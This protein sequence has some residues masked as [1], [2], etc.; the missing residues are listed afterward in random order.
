MHNLAPSFSV[1]ERLERMWHIQKREISAADF[2]ERQKELVKAAQEHPGELV[3]IDHLITPK[4]E[5]GFSQHL[6]RLGVVLPEI[7]NP[8]KGMSTPI[9]ANYFNSDDLR[10]WAHPIRIGGAE[11]SDSFYTHDRVIGGE[12]PE[13]ITLPCFRAIYGQAAIAE[14]L[15]S[16]ANAHGHTLDWEAYLA[17]AKALGADPEAELAKERIRA[18]QRKIEIIAAMAG[19]ALFNTDQDRI[20]AVSSTMREK[21]ENLLTTDGEPDLNEITAI[22]EYGM[23]AGDE[24]HIRRLQED[25]ADLGITEIEYHKILARL[26]GL[27][28]PNRAQTN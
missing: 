28:F 5:Q 3:L 9:T 15:A 22:G 26:V 7:P 16:P 17:M 25:M 12:V 10:V 13:L 21:A 14:Y 24:Y 1:S 11:V 4:T 23:R 6:Y 27:P 19:I 8:K 20:N 18:F 2:Y